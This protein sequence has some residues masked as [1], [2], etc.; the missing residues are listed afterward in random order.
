M[1][2]ITAPKRKPWIKPDAAT[3]ATRIGGLAAEIRDAGFRENLLVVAVLKGGFVF[4]ADLIRALDPYHPVVMTT[5][6][7]SMINY[8]R[9]WDTHWTQAYG[10]PAGVV[11]Q[12]DEHR[13]V[14]RIGAPVPA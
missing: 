2:R 9:T 5:W 11:R 6:N 14:G 13:L 7:K 4:A 1:L 8:R 3:I 10:D 12:I